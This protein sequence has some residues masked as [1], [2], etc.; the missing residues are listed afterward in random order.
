MKRFLIIFKFA[1]KF[2]SR[3]PVI[4][5]DGKVTAKELLDLGVAIATELGYD[6]DTEGFDLPKFN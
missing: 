5:A 3:I 4:L 1:R 2:A 6:V